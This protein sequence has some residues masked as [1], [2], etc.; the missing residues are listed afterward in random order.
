MPTVKNKLITV[1]ALATI[2]QVA[3]P[4]QKIGICRFNHDLTFGKSKIA[5]LTNNLDVF[6]HLLSPAAPHALH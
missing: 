2:T 3:A 1:K 6:F 5:I 4:L